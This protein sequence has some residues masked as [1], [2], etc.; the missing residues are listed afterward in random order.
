[1]FQSYG[2]MWL[3][4][5]S[6]SFSLSQI[7]LTQPDTLVA[8]L[9]TS[10][11]NGY[12]ISCYNCYNGSITTNV[13]GGISPYTYIWKTG[14]TTANINNL[15]TGEYTQLVTDANGCR[16]RNAVKMWQPGIGGWSFS[17]DNGDTSK[18][19]GLVDNFPFIMKTNNT[20][21]M[22]ITETGNVG[23]GT[24]LAH[25]ANNY[26]LAVNGKIG[27]K[28]ILIE[29][30]S[31]AWSDF[32]F[33]PTYKRMTFLEKEKY[34][35]KEKHLP[36]IIS[37]NE[38]GTNGLDITKVMSGITQNVEENTLDIVEL[39]KQLMDLKKENMELK[40]KIDGLTKKQ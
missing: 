4:T 12:P 33:E 39:Y 36:N 3:F 16:V 25:N 24:T 29:T 13:T 10:D 26:K 31:D 5:Y 1:M 9:T 37:A 14:Q 6:N 19:I 18:F 34:Y 40:Q 15:G 17:G 2:W 8:T 38:I 11:Y 23:I 20:E 21:Q 35:T 27:A 28:E 32:D 30:K 7:T 22:R